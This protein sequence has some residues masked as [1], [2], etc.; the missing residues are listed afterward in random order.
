MQV[1]VRHDAHIKG[2]QSLIDAVTAMV[3]SGLHGYGEHIT[4]LEVH[5]ADENGP[6][7]GGDAI[8]CSIEARFEGRPPTGLSHKGPSVEV[9]VETCVDK[10]NRMLEHELGRLRK[11]EITS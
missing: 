2:G 5:L 7:T 3:E 4:T 10:L 11:A 9:A 1:Q 6:K 8:R